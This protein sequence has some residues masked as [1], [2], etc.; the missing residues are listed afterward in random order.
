MMRR[1]PILLL[2]AL[3]LTASCGSVQ[4]AATDRPPGTKL[5]SGPE[6]AGDRGSGREVRPQNEL[7]NHAVPPAGYRVPDWPTEGYAPQFNA[8]IVPR[9]EGQFTGTT[10]QILA[11]GA[12]RWGFPADVVRAMAVE[13]SG[14]VQSTTGDISDDPGA[15]VGGARPPCPTSFG[16]LQLKATYR[17]GSWPYSQQDTAFNVDYAL[18]VVR[19]CYE[20]WITYLHNGYRAGDLWGC[21]GWHYS[22]E[23]R[24]TDALGYISRVRSALAAQS[25]RHW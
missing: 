16:I 15:C 20:G 12:C 5:R 25:W 3:L 22:G 9:I 18:A 23:W 6:C 2:V 19:G 11:W 21:L 8:V 10:D 13:E 4:A 17:P 7:A 1:Q 14:W 24:D